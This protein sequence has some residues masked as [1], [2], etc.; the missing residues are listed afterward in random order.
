VSHYAV[1]LDSWWASLEDEKF[2]GKKGW[3]VGEGPTCTEGV[4]EHTEGVGEHTRQHC[5]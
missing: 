5:C 3:K 2:R 1:Q 4:G